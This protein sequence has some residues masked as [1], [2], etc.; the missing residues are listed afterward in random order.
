MVLVLTQGV[1]QH[2]AQVVV[3]EGVLIGQHIVPNPVVV[4]RLALAHPRLV[5]ALNGAHVVLGHVG[6]VVNGSE[7]IGVTGLEVQFAGD[8]SDLG[9]EVGQILVDV[10]HAVLVVGRGNRI[11][12]VV[13]KADRLGRAVV[14]GE[15]VVVLLVHH[16]IDARSVER[17]LPGRIVGRALFALGEDAVE[18]DLQP[19]GGLIVQRGAEVHAPVVVLHIHHTILV[20]VVDTHRVGGL[21]AAARDGQAVVGDDCRAQQFLVP[22]GVGAVGPVVEVP[23]AVTA[24]VAVNRGLHRRHIGI[25]VGL[26][27]H[28]GILARVRH[29]QHVGGFLDTNVAVVGDLGGL[30]LV[31]VLGG[32]QD[33]TVGGTHTVD[34]SGRSVLQHRHVGNVVGIQEVDV[35]IEHPVH[36]IQRAAAGERAVTAD[37]HLGALARR[38][39]VHHVHARH[40][41]LHRCHGRRRGHGEQFLTLDH[42]DGSRQVLGLGRTVTDHDNL[43]Q[44]AHVVKQLDAHHLA[45]LHLH[46]LHAHEGEFQ[47]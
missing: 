24:A 39:A 33:D 29:L 22:V 14:A 41:A 5:V 7:V 45:G 25:V 46:G 9:I 17:M 37:V 30:V 19:T 27:Q 3:A 8:E 34:G 38:T 10:V 43:V 11:V 16:G 23:V 12:E 4:V 1:T 40:L 2:D 35:V 44:V 42:G 32:D 26:H 15:R 28:R 47:D 6:A 20:Q 36:D 21:L 18:A 13:G 31:A